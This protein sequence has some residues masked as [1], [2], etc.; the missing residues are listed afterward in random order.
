[1]SKLIIL[2]GP[3]GAGK[4][5]VAHLLHERAAH[6]TGLFE[7]DFYRHTQFNNP[8]DDLEAARV[9]M[10]A[11]VKA[12]LDHGTDVIMEGILSRRKYVPYMDDLLRHHPDDNHFFYFDTSF[13]ET[14]R[15]HEGRGKREHFGAAEMREWYDRSGPWGYPGEQLI[16]EGYSAE[17]AYAMIV[18]LAGIAVRA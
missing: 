9:V 12:A 14:L 16:P 13:E 7:Q 8:H 15:R 1:M 2:R 3:A 4:S 18:G 17:E 5:T 11:G 6:K 10:F